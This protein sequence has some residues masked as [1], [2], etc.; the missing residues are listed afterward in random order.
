[1]NSGHH[2]IDIYNDNQIYNDNYYLKR[3]VTKRIQVALYE[4]V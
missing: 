1:M 3:I 2:G 4:C